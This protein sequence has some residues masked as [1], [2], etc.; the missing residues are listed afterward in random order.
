MTHTKSFR[1]INH[2]DTAS[3]SP[4]YD[5]SDAYSGLWLYHLTKK[6][7]ADRKIDNF[8]F[9]FSKKYLYYFLFSLAIFRLCKI[10]IV[11]IQN[12]LYGSANCQRFCK[13]QFQRK[14]N[15][16]FQ[17]SLFLK[18]AKNVR[19]HIE[20]YFLFVRRNLKIVFVRQ[21]FIERK[22]D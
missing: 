4:Q 3:K 9:L 10:L 2:L 17:S 21:Y 13:F 20:F 19:E 5:C 22:I 12:G 15:K 6:K 7:S 8:P 11:H 14:R 18:K 16:F 1:D